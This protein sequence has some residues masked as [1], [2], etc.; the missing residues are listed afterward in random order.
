MQMTLSSASN[1]KIITL[2]IYTSS[3]RFGTPR[4]LALICLQVDYS[5]HVNTLNLR[6]CKSGERIEV[7]KKDAECVFLRGF[8]TQLTAWVTSGDFSIPLL[9]YGNTTAG[10]MRKL[11]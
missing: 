5:T 6:A 11:S 2:M 3:S 4:N 1:T 10:K 9:E 8:A 7:C